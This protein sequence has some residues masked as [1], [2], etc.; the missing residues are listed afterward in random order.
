MQK[1]MILARGFD[2]VTDSVS[3]I[4]Q[5]APARFVTFIGCH[6]LR[7]DCN[8]SLNELFEIFAIEIFQHFEKFGI[9]DDGVLD[10]FG[11]ALIQF[12]RR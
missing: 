3:E 11:K 9:A 2:R 10:D 4:K 5:R 8:I 7:L 1:V 6:E 12:A